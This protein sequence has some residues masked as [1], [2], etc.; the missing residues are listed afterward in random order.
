MNFI[1][2]SKSLVSPSMLYGLAWPGLFVCTGLATRDYLHAA[3]CDTDAGWVGCSGYFGMALVIGC[4]YLAGHRF[5]YS[6]IFGRSSLIYG[7]G[8]P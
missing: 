3:L 7:S 2:H 6:G 1:G 8:R 4:V 5:Y